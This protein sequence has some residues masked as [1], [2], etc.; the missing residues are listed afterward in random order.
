MNDEEL[1]E[2]GRQLA[3]PKGEA[4]LQIAEMLNETNTGM[5]TA[6]TDAL[7]IGDGNILLELGHGN[8]G[9]LDMLL[10]RAN[11]IQYFGLEVS[12]DMYREASRR[13]ASKVDSGAANFYLYDGEVLPF[14]DETFDRVMT[15]NTIYFWKDPAAL[16][17]ELARV[18]KPGGLIALAF[19]EKT[20]MKDL[21][22]T[23]ESFTLVDSDE[24]VM[25]LELAG[26]TIKEKLSKT[27][28]VK[29][30]AGDLVDREYT[31]VSASKDL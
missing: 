15:V 9:H 4:G 21:P 16:S 26:L 17:K 31:V 8:C 18:M 20:F 3:H 25:W 28:K 27:E 6:A 10:A 29:T 2:Y 23:R 11:E 13:N 12:Q 30:R 19:G 14:E 7:N 5:T 1:K 22:F 24:V